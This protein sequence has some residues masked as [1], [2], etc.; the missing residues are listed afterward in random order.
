MC[1][2]LKTLVNHRS[3]TET[4]Y[5][6]RLFCRNMKVRG[7]THYRSDVLNCAMLTAQM[8]EW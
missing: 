1:S 6:E 3:L 7:T 4:A 5:F 8:T 2:E